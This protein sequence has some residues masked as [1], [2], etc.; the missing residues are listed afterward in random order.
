MTLLFINPFCLLFIESSIIAPIAEVR[1]FEP[2]MRF[3]TYLISSQAPST[4]QPHLLILF[5]G[6]SSR[7]LGTP[8]GL[9][10][11]IGHPVFAGRMKYEAVHIS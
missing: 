10:C 7:L 6:A 1:G 2:L 11:D 3:P 4:T 9:S 5:V 8:Y